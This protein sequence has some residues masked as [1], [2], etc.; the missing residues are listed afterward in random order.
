MIRLSKLADYGTA[1]MTRLARSPLEIKSARALAADTRMNTPTVSKLLKIL[2]ESGLVK[3]ERGVNGGY[4]L[5]RR[6]DSITIADVI[7]AIEGG[8]ALTECSKIM[9]YCA[10][11]PHCGVR[12]NWQLINQ[13][14]MTALQS[15]TLADMTTTL[16]FHPMVRN[17]QE[18]T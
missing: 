18:I 6:P 5:A 2:Q 13:V 10:Q 1:I 9:A 12:D 15:V 4:M 3:A 8:P 11:S 7:A 14:I 16:E 17:M